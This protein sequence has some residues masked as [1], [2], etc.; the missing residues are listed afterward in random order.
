MRIVIKVGSHVLAENGGL[1]M[2]RIANLCDF[3][4]D[5]MQKHEVI[6]VS[7]GAVAAGHTKLKLDK[8]LMKNKQAIAAVGQPYLISVYQ[9][10]FEKNDIFVAQVL[11]GADDFDS[12]RHT[13]HAKKAVDT[14]LKNAVLPIINEND[15]TSVEELVFGDNDQLSAH[16]T[17]RFDAD[18]LVILS[19]IDGYYDDDPR[20]NKDAEMLHMVNDISQED[21]AMPHLPTNEFAT[22]GIVTKLKAAAYLLSHDREM[23]LASGFDLSDIRAFLLEGK[24][25][26]GTHFKKSLS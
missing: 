7:S 3:L 5:L 10:L 24:P 19:D 1:A 23:F 9:K 20:T 13:K 14:L 12:R 21:L 4:M 6:L 16:V 25:E 26:G 15:V 17:H 18:L 22:G 11:L 8:S 2:E